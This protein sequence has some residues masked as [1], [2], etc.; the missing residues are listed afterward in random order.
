VGALNQIRQKRGTP[1]LLFCD[2]GS[3]FTS[4]M[5]DLWAY[6]NDVR[7]DLSRPG[8]PTDN[9]HVGSFNGTCEPSV[10]TYIGSR[11]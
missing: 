3:E 7:I 6:H 11:H 10:W 4:Q 5:M 2:S 1:K 8:K 9:A